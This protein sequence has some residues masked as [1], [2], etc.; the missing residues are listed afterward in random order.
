MVDCPEQA[1]TIQVMA[2]SIFP[3]LGKTGAFSFVFFAPF[4]TPRD[5]GEALE[6]P[7]VVKVKPGDA[8]LVTIRACTDA[9]GNG[10]RRYT[11][12]VH[13][14]GSSEALLTELIVTS[15]GSDLTLSPPFDPSVSLYRVDIP[16]SSPSTKV[17][18]VAGKGGFVSYKSSM[19]VNVPAKSSPW[20][21]EEVPSN[22][23]A[24]TKVKIFVV[25]ANWKGEMRYTLQFGRAPNSDA[26]IASMASNVGG[27]YVVGEAKQY[28]YML[29]VPLG[30]DEVAV[31]ATATDKDG[32]KVTLAGNTGHGYASAVLALD[33]KAPYKMVKI[34]VQA[35]DQVTQRS[36]LLV[37]AMAHHSSW[38]MLSDLVVPGCEA[39][40]LPPFQ[41]DVFH[42]RCLLNNDA[43]RVK[44][45]P[46]V[47]WMPGFNQQMQIRIKAQ[48][49][50][51]ENLRCTLFPKTSGEAL[52]VWTCLHTATERQWEG[53]GGCG[54]GGL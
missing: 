35:A 32:A 47:M 12:D 28:R 24:L 44:V 22:W 45:I 13:R 50:S 18:A 53:R 39:G 27:P 6:G 23:T 37:V 42:Y 11:L 15:G 34:H 1:D 49:R 54:G 20:G 25:S 8:T 52:E 29:E 48:N 7:Q 31:S 40:L 19:E 5:P 43:E 9:G 10:C 16:F 26:S 46:K 33:P 17:V 3:L 21:S 41:I 4:F 30:T 51:C 36:Y 14:E 2:E 38:A